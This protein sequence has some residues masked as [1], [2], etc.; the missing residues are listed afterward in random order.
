MKAVFNPPAVTL[1]L[2]PRALYLPREFEVK[3]PRVGPEGDDWG[4]GNA[5]AQSRI[6]GA[7][8]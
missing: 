5:Y 4:W 8:E 6:E 1:G 3:S 2:D 7:M